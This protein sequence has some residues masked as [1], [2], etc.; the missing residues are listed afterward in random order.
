MP[1]DPYQ[2]PRFVPFEIPKD[3]LSSEAL[4][5][6]IESYCTQYHGINDLEDPISNKGLVEKALNNGTLTIWYDPSTESAAIHPKEGNPFNP[7]R[8]MKGA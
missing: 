5:S 6:M 3:A 7:A 1:L 4:D 2:D 8:P